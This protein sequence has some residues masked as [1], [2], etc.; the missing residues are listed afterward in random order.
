MAA[1]NIIGKKTAYKEKEYP[2][3][4]PIGGKYAIFYYKK[5][6]VE[7]LP[8]WIIK[9]LVELRYLI[10]IMPLFKAIGIWFKGLKIFLQNEQLG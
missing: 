9:G 8:A 5:W 2:Y 7:G 3:I 10:K 1:K 4:L 6:A